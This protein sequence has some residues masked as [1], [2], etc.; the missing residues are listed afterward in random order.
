MIEV[1]DAPYLSRSF[2]RHAV[3]IRYNAPLYRYWFYLLQV[4]LSPQAGVLNRA[5]CSVIPSKRKLTGEFF[6]DKSFFNFGFDR[7]DL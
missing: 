3:S 5:G 6:Y 2:A 1:E 7:L 4:K